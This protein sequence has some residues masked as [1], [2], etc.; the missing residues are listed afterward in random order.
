M[1]DDVDI[2]MRELVA[3]LRAEGRSVHAVRGEDG[4]KVSLIQWEQRLVL[5]VPFVA[6]QG[7]WVEARVVAQQARG[8]SVTVAQAAAHLLTLHLRESWAVRDPDQPSGTWTYRGSTF[9]KD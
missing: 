2:L 8:T 5:V 7:L 1:T 6:L 9:V 4:W 3:T